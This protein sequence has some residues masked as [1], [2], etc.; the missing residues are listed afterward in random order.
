MTTQTA[1]FNLNGPTKGRKFSATATDATFTEITST[2][3][4]LSLG[5]VLRGVRITHYVGQFAAGIGI[6]RIR[7]TATNKVKAILVADV[8]GEEIV[9]KVRIPFTVEEGDVIEAYVDVA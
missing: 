2:T 3:G 7:N 6:G 1:L 5:D 8:I 4:T 9:R